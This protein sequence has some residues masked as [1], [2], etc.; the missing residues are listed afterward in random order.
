MKKKIL[1]VVLTLICIVSVAFGSYYL[2]SE[3]FENQYKTYSSTSNLTQKVDKNMDRVDI[4]SLYINSCVSVYV[5]TKDIGYSLG[6]GTCVAAKGYQ[7]SNGYMAERGA[8][9]VTNYHVIS[10]L[11]EEDFVDFESK[12]YIIL[13]GQDNIKTHPCNVIWHDKDLDMALLYCDDNLVEENSNFGWI[14]IKDR[15]ID[16]E[17]NQKLNFDKIFT[18]GT[19]LNLEYQNTLSQGYVSNQRLKESYTSKELYVYNSDSGYKFTTNEK[20]IPNRQTLYY[21]D[22]LNNAYQDLIMMN[23][24][25]TNGNSG[26]A[27]F[28]ENGYIVALSTLGINYQL[29][30]TSAL[31]FAVPIYPLTK[32]LDK[33][34]EFNEG[35]SQVENIIKI[36]DLK[37]SGGDFS[38]LTFMMDF[39][40]IKEC[41]ERSYYLDGKFYNA[42][43]LEKLQECDVAGFIVFSSEGDIEE[44]FVITSICKNDEE[45]IVK[46]RNQLIYCLYSCDKGEKITL[47]GYSFGDKNQEKSF[48]IEL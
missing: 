44:N 25:I 47:N 16:C 35:A 3:S 48:I 8:Y 29:A 12:A 42:E 46:N 30:N 4:A 20:V 24:D 14:E 26:G 34:I 22:V 1:A 17:S 13:N 32:V 41:G 21:Y 7:T 40:G 23:L 10:N 45:F 27:V 33:A 15:T 9:F 11:V 36:S 2:I 38:E 31:N 19:P 37:I 39:G 18:I 6:S 28:D 5:E 43:K